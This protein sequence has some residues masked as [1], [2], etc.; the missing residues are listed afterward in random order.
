VVSRQ[1]I[2]VVEDHRPLL[3]AIREILEAEGYIVSTAGDGVR[4]LEAMERERP[5]LIVADIMMPHMDGYAFY[6]AVRGRAE[7]VAIPFI[8]L[9]AKAERK[10]VLRGMALGAED[11][12]TKPFDPQQLVVA[13]RARLGRARAIREAAAAEFERLKRQIVTILSHELRTP[14]TY[15]TG[16]TELALEEIPALS[17]DALQ[18]FLMGIKRGT[19]RLTGLVE[20]LLLLVRVDTGQLADE[21]GA[22]ARVC[23]DL[24]A[25][26]E[27][28]VRRFDE[29]AAAQGIALEMKVEPDL[30]PVSLCE[31]FFADALRRLVDNGIKF[32]RAGGKRVT[33]TVRAAGDWV[34]VAVQDEGVGIPAEQISHL[35]ERFQQV[36]RERMEQQGGG[37]GLAIA[38]DLILLHG[39]DIVAESKP[40][41]GSTFTIRLP[42]LSSD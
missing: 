9:T 39:G 32:S 19:D 34:E 16:Y 2:L 4:A 13:V 30:P 8:F 36:E 3:T 27:S 10:D 42:S 5:H 29:Q 26:V 40:G 24:G 28:A 25:V 21:F 37:L 41:V 12:L 7:W 23:R 35:F 14:L 11:Y 1:H 17:P 38:R 15:I 31:P 18:E 22:L 20:D 33:V 6:E